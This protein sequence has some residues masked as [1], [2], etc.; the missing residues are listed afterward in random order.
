MGAGAKL[1]WLQTPSAITG[2]TLPTQLF[3]T[4]SSSSSTVLCEGV[5]FSAITGTIADLTG[6]NTQYTFVGCKL[7]ASATVANTALVG[8]DGMLTLINCDS[9]AT[10]YRH[11]KH[12]FAGVQT[13]DIAV[14]R[15]G[16]ATNGTTPIAWKIA[17]DADAEFLAP[18]ESL[19]ISIWN[20]TSG[21]SRTL[22]VHGIWGGGSVPTNENIWIEVKY[23][24]SA[25][26]PLLSRAS[27]GK[28]DFLA[29]ATNYSAD[30][31]TWGGSTTDWTMAVTFTPMMKG[32]LTVR[33]Y[34]A[35]ASST[36]YIDPEPVL[37]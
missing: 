10:N 21:S 14:V 11:E 29:V 2:A 4:S 5:D 28:A 16:G 34:A 24:G 30:T 23:P 6:G 26:T 1:T 31:S 33:V 32:P 9:G 22:T 8:D 20:D 12:T 27:S 25:T 35:L 3:N 18:F 19:P 36:F 17:T 15:S 7:H 37:T 13:V